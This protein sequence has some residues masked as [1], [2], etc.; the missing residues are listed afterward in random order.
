MSNPIPLQRL[1]ARDLRAAV[2]TKKFLALVLTTV[3][4][5]GLSIVMAVYANDILAY[6]LGSELGTAIRAEDLPPATDATVWQQWTNNLVQMV[7]LVLG[8]IVAYETNRAVYSPAGH[9]MF[10]RPVVRTHVLSANLLMNLLV[11][12]VAAVIGLVLVVIGAFVMFDHVSVAPVI[13]GTLTWVV[14]AMLMAT[15]GQLFGV[16]LS[17]RVGAIGVTVALY[18]VLLTLG[19]APML[20]EN[21]PAGL[22]TLP[23][24]L[25]GGDMPPVTEFGLPLITGAAVMLVAILASSQILEKKDL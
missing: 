8:V 2:Q 6:A 4:M 13:L 18:F 7:A 23:T 14:C 12:V 22:F 3:A 11:A 1:M 15:F 9:L 20:A 21:T 17:S 24:L 10:T 19:A 25:A 5:A 16:L